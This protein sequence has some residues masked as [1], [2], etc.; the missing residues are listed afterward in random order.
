MV[1]QKEL[2]NLETSIQIYIKDIRNILNCHNVA[3]HCKFDAHNSVRPLLV[4]GDD[5][6]RYIAYLDMLQQCLIPQLDEDDQEGRIHFQQENI[7][8]SLP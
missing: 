4:H 6:Y 1:L 8:P 3:K 7:L 2:Y 5:R